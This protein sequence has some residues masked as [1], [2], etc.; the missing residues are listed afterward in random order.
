MLLVGCIMTISITIACAVMVFKI[1]RLHMHYKEKAAEPYMEANFGAS[2]A[3]IVHASVRY[4]RAL[5]TA[6]IITLAV[7]A[8]SMLIC[9]YFTL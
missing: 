3:N 8:V 6:G 5:L 1:T 4:T 9:L 2:Y 7:S